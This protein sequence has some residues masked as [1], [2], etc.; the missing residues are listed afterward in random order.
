MDDVDSVQAQI[1]R[2]MLSSGDWVTATLDGVRY[3][4]KA[5]LWYW[6]IAVCFKVFG[7]HDWVARIPVIFSC[8]LL[9]WLTARMGRW[10]FSPQAGFYSGLVIATGVGMFLFT[11][12][13]IPDV[14]LTLFI[15]LSLWAFLRALDDEEKHPRL[16]AAV[17]PVGIAV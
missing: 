7:V 14:C 1:A 16:W 13:L 6:M 12:I 10:A 3:L 17:C 4:E 15:A 11:R 2:N 5:P 8:V 9:T